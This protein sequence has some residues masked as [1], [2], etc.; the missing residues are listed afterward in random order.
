MR[1]QENSS[2]SRANEVWRRFVGMFG[3]DAVHRKYGQ[4]IPP[5]W[6]AVLDKL[7]MREVERGMRRLVYSGRDAVPSLP[8][9]VKLCRT[10]GDE[11]D[12][13]PAEHRPALP[14]PGDEQ[15]AWQ[16][17]GN[18]HL[19]AHVTRTVNENPQCYGRPATAKAMKELPRETH[20]NADASPEFI[21]NMGLL[22]AAKNAWVNAMRV[23]G[24]DAPVDIQQGCW[25]QHIE[26][27]EAEIAE[28]MKA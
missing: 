6:P 13:G 16:V 20:P 23:Y 14:A 11:I 1:P 26:A 25:K 10:I 12:D 17:A 9:F 3:G 28:R 7:P 21:A 5:E 15:D 27:A 24:G 18:R 8:A 4:S 22:V 2:P 19:Q